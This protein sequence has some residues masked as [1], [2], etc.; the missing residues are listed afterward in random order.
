ME[1]T[2]TSI[3]GVMYNHIVKV[4]KFTPITCRTK[5]RVDSLFAGYFWRM[6]I[7]IQ[8]NNQFITWIRINNLLVECPT[9]VSIQNPSEKTV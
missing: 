2:P 4:D 7:W 9:A 6:R 8:G 5:N 1:C 3:D